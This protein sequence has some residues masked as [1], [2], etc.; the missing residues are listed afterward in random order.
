MGTGSNHVRTLE[1]GVFA[2]GKFAFHLESRLQT[3]EMSFFIVVPRF[4]ILDHKN[5]NNQ[6]RMWL[7]K[8]PVHSLELDILFCTFSLS[9]LVM[10]LNMLAEMILSGKLSGSCRFH[11]E[12]VFVSPSFE[13][14]AT[15]LLIHKSAW[16]VPVRL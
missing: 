1:H 15:W 10:S 5:T 6:V 9:Q 7:R 12:Y 4:P 14:Q 3:D 2:G 11:N 16:P 13:T 8:K